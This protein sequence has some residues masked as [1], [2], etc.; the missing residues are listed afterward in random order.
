MELALYHHGAGYYTRPSGSGAVGDY[1]TSAAGH[2]V[3]GALLAIQFQGMWQALD[4]PLRFHV[5]EMGAGN[6]LLAR[7]VVD[8]AGQLQG[9]FAAS[10]RYTALERRLS[11]G[12]S[13]TRPDHIEW[14]TTGDIPLRG[15]VGCFFSNELVDAFPVHR[16][17]IQ[18]GQ[19][20][21]IYVALDE[22]GGF[23][24]VLEEPSTPLSLGISGLGRSL[25]DGFRGEINLNIEPWV[26]AFSDALERGFVLT[27]DYGYRAQELYAPTRAEGTLQTYYR[28]TEG[29]SPY[30]R[31][32]QQDITAHVNFSA[33]AAAGRSVA[34]NSLGLRTQRQFLAD[35]GFGAMVEKLRAM[36]LSQRERN[37][38]MMA[39][40]DLVKRKDLAPSRF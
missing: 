13:T 18:R 17:Q 4:R 11:I 33:I 40:L 2:P 8:Y 6:G 24:E 38:N 36:E 27:I 12:N 1:Y 26:S 5:V 20:R 9:E 32:G 23:T 19:I 35:L 28:H 31:I 22:H 37:A 10:L 3:F 21:E 39:M 14:I 7:D 30:R 34:L 25:G 29:V 15:V 16:F